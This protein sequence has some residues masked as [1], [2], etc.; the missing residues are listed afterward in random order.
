MNNP[1][2]NNIIDTK[3][4]QISDVTTNGQFDPNKFNNEYNVIRDQQIK[5]KIKQEEISLNEKYKHIITSENE[6]NNKS[7]KDLTLNELVKNTY[8][9][10]FDIFNKILQGTFHYKELLFSDKLFY[11]GLF[12]IFVTIIM[13]LL[14]FA[15]TK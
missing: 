14:N 5:D 11:L 3:N 9:T 12:L 10:T 7:I 2:Q 4:I 8:T 15:V 1:S 6:K 13:Y